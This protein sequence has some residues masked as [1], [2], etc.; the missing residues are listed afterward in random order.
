MAPSAGLESTSDG[1][2]SFI[3]K[4]LTEVQKSTKMDMRLIQSRVES[5][6]ESSKTPNVKNWKSPPLPNF[7]VKDN[8]LNL[9]VDDFDILKSLKPMIGRSWLD[10]TMQERKS[11][12][13]VVPRIDKARESG[14]SR[15][16]GGAEQER[17][18]RI[19]F[20]PQGDRKTFRVSKNWEEPLKKV[21]QTVEESL[22]DL[23][24]TAA[25]S[26]TPGEFFENVQKTEFFENVKKN[27][28]FARASD[29]GTNTGSY[30][31]DVA[32]LTI[33]ELFEAVMRESEPLLDHLGIRKD[34]TK[35]FREVVT[36]PQALS[37]AS[38]TQR[39]LPVTVKESSAQD[40]LDLRIASVI[41]STGYK[42]K[43]GLLTEKQTLQP[44]TKDLR[45]NIAIVTTASLPWM[46]G[47]AVN[48]LFRAAYLARSGEQKVNLLVPWLCKKDQVLVYPN[49]ITFE[50]PAEQE[51][52]VRKWVEDRVGFQCDFKLSFYPGKFSTEKR[53]ILAAGDISQ[54]IPNQEADVAVLEEPEHLNWYYHGRR[55][56]DK[57]Q[58]VVGVVHTNYLEYVKRERNGSVQAFLL[59]HVNNWVVRI[60]CNKVLRLS[61]ATQDLPRSSVCNVHGVNPQFL[62]IGK[63]LAEIE[64]NEPKFSMGA[65][66]LGKMVWGKGYRELVDLLV[67][68][69]EVLCNINLDIFGSGEDS[70]AVRDEAQQNGLALNFYPGR[71]HA[72]AS[73][74]GYKVFINPSESDVVCTT[75]AEALAMG[76]IVVCADHPSNEFFMPF[77]NCYTYRTPEEFVEK[78][79]LALSSEPLPLTPEL[80]HLLSWEA[81]TDRFI[82]SAGVKSLP[83][84][85]ARTI[86]RKRKRRIP[87]EAAKGRTMSLSLALP[88]KTLSNM[89]DTGLAF[90]HYFLSGIEIARIAA[91]GLPGTMNIGEEY[92]KDLDLPPTPPRIVYGW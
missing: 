25:A 44:A 2:L 18:R 8:P 24:T 90:S 41:Q 85:E 52:F 67:Q 21:K 58:H 72:D 43:G 17:D 45:R 13:W 4:S 60:Y 66:Y 35:K 92:R 73:L 56:T 64:G 46:T 89:I 80:Q 40:E 55:W 47:T 10:A 1:V 39:A 30:G 15:D 23:E 57:F 32:P 74:H 61:A 5:F 38:V 88:K 62:R 53:S 63:G 75:T 70:D 12:L 6:R 48:P 42:F 65:Y 36:G 37:G 3:S 16:R 31:T 26:K 49:Q 28:K 20:K 76:K 54:F 9:R 68:N 69:K 22:R 11:E 59:K 79:K 51:R 71:D 86:E 34:V 14:K 87:I 29:V 82:D 50:T 91:G 77:P 81:A 84:R 19:L 83:P 33:P 27:L 78:V 7:S